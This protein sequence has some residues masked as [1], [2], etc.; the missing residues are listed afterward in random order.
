MAK[1]AVTFSR[2]YWG[3]GSMCDIAIFAR[4]VPT[5]RAQNARQR[6]PL[7]V[8]ISRLIPADATRPRSGHS[9]ASFNHLVRAGEDRRGDGQA[10]RLGGAEI[11]HQLAREPSMLPTERAG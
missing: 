2:F 8:K 7:V 9:P 10:E 11:D 4:G 5:G 3:A 1:F 6:R